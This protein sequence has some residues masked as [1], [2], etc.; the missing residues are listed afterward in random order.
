MPFDVTT[1]MGAMVALQSLNNT[2]S[3]LTSTQNRIS[4]VR[5]TADGVDNGAASAVAQS[6][7]RDRTSFS[8]DNQGGGAQDLGALVDA[9]MAQQSAR[10]QAQQV[11]QQLGAQALSIANQAPQS[12]MKLFG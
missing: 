3:A 5:R 12:L 1:N 4:T 6:R 2:Q 10:L 7:Q 9:D 11:R 8:F